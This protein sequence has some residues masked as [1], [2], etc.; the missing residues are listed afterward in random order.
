MKRKPCKNCSCKRTYSHN[1]S[2]LKFPIPMLCLGERC[3]V[4]G[5]IR[6]SFYGGRISYSQVNDIVS[7]QHKMIFNRDTQ[8][9]ALSL[10]SRVGTL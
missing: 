2:V 3:K 1:K 9:L 5:T 8:R 7:G 6:E 4:C 10:F